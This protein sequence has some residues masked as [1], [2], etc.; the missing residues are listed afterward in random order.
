MRLLALSALAVLLTS[1]APAPVLDQAMVLSRADAKFAVEL[2]SRHTE[3]VNLCEPCGE[4]EPTVQPFGVA[5]TRPWSPDPTMWE[6]LVDG[7]SKDLAYVFVAVT[8]ESGPTTY[9]N[10]AL[11]LGLPVTS[12]S[13]AITLPE[14][15]D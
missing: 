3:V 11:L 12:V 14:R 8:P 10:M 5:Y 15:G 6:V 13:A 4:T 2:L 1:A 7:E 9:V